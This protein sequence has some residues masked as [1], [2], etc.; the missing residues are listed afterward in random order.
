MPT[1]TSYSR[2]INRE[3]RGRSRMVR[4]PVPRRSRRSWRE[5]A[6]ARDTAM[7]D[8]SARK[9]VAHT[10]ITITTT[11]EG[12]AMITAQPKGVWP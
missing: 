3:D 2:R 5:P 10:L 8:R 4:W 12:E 11:E 7:C 9:S 1:L 6:S